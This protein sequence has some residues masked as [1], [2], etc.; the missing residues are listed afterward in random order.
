M[1]FY[2]KPITNYKIECETSDAAQTMQ[3]FREEFNFD[4]DNS[5]SWRELL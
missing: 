2:Q 3:N 5:T 1:K 4:L